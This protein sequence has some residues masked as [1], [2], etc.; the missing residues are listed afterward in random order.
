MT[1]LSF[2]QIMYLNFIFTPTLLFAGR[3]WFP[4]NFHS[5]LPIL[6][7]YYYSD[8]YKFSLIFSKVYIRL[9]CGLPLEKYWLKVL[10]RVSKLRYRTLIEALIKSLYME[11]LFLFDHYYLLYSYLTYFQI[12]FKCLK[13]FFTA[14]ILY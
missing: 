14:Y 8:F 3:A 2:S 9:F 6:S 5:Y 11:D 7:Y 13:I 1:I 10:P 12:Q 4:L